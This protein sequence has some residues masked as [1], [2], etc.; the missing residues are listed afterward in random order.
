MLAFS[1]KLSTGLLVRS[2][3][4]LYKL[5]QLLRE[6]KIFFQAETAFQPKVK[7]AV[8]LVDQQNGARNE[9]F[10]LYIGRKDT[11]CY[12]DVSAQRHVKND[13]LIFS[14]TNRKDVC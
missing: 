7:V 1:V 8:I 2:L 14:I 13:Q 4:I 12:C 11:K 10:H 5:N 9:N 3:K 6:L